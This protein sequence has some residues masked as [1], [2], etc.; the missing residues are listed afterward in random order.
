MKVFVYRA[1]GEVIGVVVASD[2]DEA[3]QLLELPAGTDRRVHL[4]IEIID[5]SHGAQ[6]VLRGRDP[7]TGDTDPSPPREA[8]DFAWWS[9][10]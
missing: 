5:P 1:L 8:D 6:V 10:E 3:E 7:W 4:D 2:P 9:D